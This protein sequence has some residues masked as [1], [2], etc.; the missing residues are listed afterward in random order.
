MMWEH[1][2]RWLDDTQLRDPIEHQQASLLQ[3]ML[4]GMIVA[5]S[6][7][8]INNLITS[9]TVAR[10]IFGTIANTLLIVCAASG[11]ILLRRGRFRL[12]VLVPAV[13]MA[14]LIG[15]LGIVLGSTNGMGLAILF[16]VPITL[17]GL[18]IGR[19][20]LLLVI[21]ISHVSIL[22][23]FLFQRFAP[24]LAGFVPAQID[25]LPR[26]VF[27]FVIVTS[28]LGVFLDRFGSSLNLALHAAL[29]REQEL[30]HVRAM[31][32]TIIAERT[33]DL[34]MNIDQLRATHATI[35][36]LGAPILPI[37]PGVLVA[38]LIG[39]IDS[40]RARVLAEKILASVAHQRAQYVIFD[41]T[42]VPIVDTHTAQA[43]IHTATAVHLLGAQTA[44]V[45]I[46]PEVAQTIVALNIDFGAIH[47]YPNLQEA[48]E[49]LLVQRA[50]IVA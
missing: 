27:V 31:Q 47:T 32:E 8:L 45:G 22:L 10:Q 28:L 7:A 5:A 1:I 25:I 50:G 17:A 36:E 6:L 19:R 14:L 48:V 4:I 37:L 46:R 13:G 2:R 26:I 12:A 30:Q 39:I 33:A 38:P 3:I 42:G 44:I 29:A 16:T 20:G 21:G 41:I 24:G 23:I 18:L 35:Y 40:D 11:I 43:L 15:V 9:E 34:Q 49:A